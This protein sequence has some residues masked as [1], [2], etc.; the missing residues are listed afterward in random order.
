MTV[1][2]SSRLMRARM[3]MTLREDSGSSDAMGSSASTTLAPCTRVRAIAAR[4]CCPPDSVDARC[5]W[6]SAMPTRWSASS[7]SARSCGLNMRSQPRHQGVRCSNPTSTFI[8]TGKRSTR[9]NCWNTKPTCERTWR[10]SLW[11]RPPCCT[12]RPSTSI[13]DGLDASATTKPA[14]WRSKV[15]L[16]EPEAPISATI[17]PRCT[18]RLMSRRACLPLAKCLFSWWTCSAAVMAASWGR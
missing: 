8:S 1:Q 9:L 11:M 13:S 14:T 10:M 2:R 7:A 12:Q 16:P 5:A 4:C 3:S 18:V 6:H 17:S 15:D